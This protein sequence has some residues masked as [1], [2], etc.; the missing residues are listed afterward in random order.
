V[1]TIPIEVVHRTPNGRLIDTLGGS[2][3]IIEAEIDSGHT[4]VVQAPDGAQTIHTFWYSWAA[5]HPETEI[6]DTE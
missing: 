4:P 2:Q 3:L 5:T 6:Y 1:R